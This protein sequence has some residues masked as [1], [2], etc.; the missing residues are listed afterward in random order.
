MSELENNQL[1]EVKNEPIIG[2]FKPKRKFLNFV[3]AV[4][5]ARIRYIRDIAFIKGEKL[6][7]MLEGA[8]FKITICDEGTIKF[9]EQE[10]TNFSDSSMIKRLINNIDEIDVTGYAQKFVVAGLEFADI[11]GNRCYLEV[12]HDKPIDKLKSIFDSDEPEL[13]EKGL[14]ILDDLFGSD[15]DEIELSEND[16]QIFVEEIENPSEP[17]EDLKSTSESY[18]EE[19]FRKM[20]EQKIQELKT[21]IEDHH[22]E[23]TKQELDTKRAES[24]IKEN[25][26]SIRIL[27]SRLDSMQ[28]ND[29]PNGYVFFVSEEKKNE[30]GLDES[31][32]HIADKI[33]DI[34]GLKKDVLFEMLTSSYH[35]IK[36][37]KKGDY[38]PIDLNAKIESEEQVEQIKKDMQNLAIMEQLI[39]Q[40]DIDGDFSKS[41]E[42]IVYR[43]SLNWHQLVGK[44]IKKGFEQDP[45]FDK[46]AGSNSYTKDDD[47][48]VESDG[49]GLDEFATPIPDGEYNA[50]EIYSSDVEQN[51]VIFG[52]S[53]DSNNSFKI[54]ND[55]SFLDIRI[56]QKRIDLLIETSGSVTVMTLEDYLKGSNYMG[57]ES[58]FIP[59]FKGKI[60]V[61]VKTIDGSYKD[62]I[63]FNEYLEDQFENILSVFVNISEGNEVFKLNGE[64]DFKKIKSIVRD[65][66]ISK[67]LDKK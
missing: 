50:K 35:V 60:E 57:I 5:G 11:D 63:D 4:N 51:I 24:K 9:E 52:H 55:Y 19:S 33:A 16:L 53:E 20:N 42:G 28:P 56:D 6:S 23:I 41:D 26:D 3:S 7:G 67:I 66:T 38:T 15:E 31:T 22:K 46:I 37:S 39:K 49:F 54:T 40:I 58:L 62:N 59:N 34:M 21:R 17:N 48:V 32:K 36:I 14:S 43:G 61:G 2:E 44:M 13:S 8:I 65:E 29:L 47:N 27:E 25:K 10:G 30:T 12:E 45:E 1:E 64:D 18:M